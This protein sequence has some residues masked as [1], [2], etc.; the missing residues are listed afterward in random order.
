MRRLASAF[1]PAWRRPNGVARLDQAVVDVRRLL[2]RDVELVAELAEVGD[3]DAQHAREADVDLARG[4]ERERLV[5][6]V[7]AGDRLQQLARARPLHV[8]LRV[9]GGHVG[10]E[11]VRVVRDVAP[12]PGLD[13]AVRGVGR[14]DPEAL[15]V[16]LG[17]GEVGLELA[18]PR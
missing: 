10:D 4:A 15:V 18:A 16:E 3:A 5:R 2:G 12:H 13:V 17:D 7:G 8:D 9:A 6:Q 14:D 11:G 1:R